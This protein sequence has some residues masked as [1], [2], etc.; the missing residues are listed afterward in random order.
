MKLTLLTC[1]A[2][3]AVRGD[4]ALLRGSPSNPV[5]RDY[6]AVLTHCRESGVALRGVSRTDNERHGRCEATGL[7]G[8]VRDY[9][10]DG[11]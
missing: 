2:G 7:R 4:D 3:L 10:W 8:L 5:Y 6:Q 9:H 1:F 11:L